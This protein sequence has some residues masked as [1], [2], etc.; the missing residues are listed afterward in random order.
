MAMSNTG[1][2]DVVQQQS[3]LK[4]VPFIIDENPFERMGYEFAGWSR[5]KNAATADVQQDGFSAAG[6][7]SDLDL[8][9]IWRPVTLTFTFDPNGGKFQNGQTDTYI[10]SNIG[11]GTFPNIGA[12][13]LNPTRDGYEF[14]GWYDL[15]G[16]AKISQWTF[17]AMDNMNFLA[18]WTQTGANQEPDIPQAP[19]NAT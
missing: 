12:A 13:Y 9:A 6:I 8:Y 14:N 3:V 16:G 4:D 19:S 7:S 1:S 5:N 11:F 15:N 2:T 17:Y 10:M 18:K